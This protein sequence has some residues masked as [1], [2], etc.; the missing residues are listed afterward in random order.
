MSDKL[1]R[2]KRELGIGARANKYRVQLAAQNAL[3]GTDI[4]GLEIDT[5][6]KGGAIP[7]KTIGTVDVWTQGRKLVIA[8]D[9]AY[10]HTWALTFYTTQ[11][12]ALRKKFDAWLLFIDDVESHSRA[13]GDMDEH[14]DDYFAQIAII[15]QLDTS[16]NKVT[17]EYNF[18]NLWPTG[19]SALDMADDTQ[20]AVLE[21]TVDFAFSHWT[22]TGLE[23]LSF[24]EGEL[25]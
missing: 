18:Q 5:L 1:N 3:T 25:A 12:H 4:G 14:H 13:I 8:G 6:C 17:A 23:A 19:I 11:D 21:F 16:T 24:D 10:E 2:L 7:A 15:Q 20:D 9:A 22:M